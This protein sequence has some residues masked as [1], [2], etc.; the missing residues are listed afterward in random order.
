MP[1]TIMT[2]SNV[3]GRSPWNYHVFR[4]KIIGGNCDHSSLSQCLYEV[5]TIINIYSRWGKQGT[6]DNLHDQ[7]SLTSATLGQMIS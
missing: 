7:A 4:S 2:T 5:D 6:G 3:L 1:D